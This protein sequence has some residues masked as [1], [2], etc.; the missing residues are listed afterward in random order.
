[1]SNTA[2]KLRKNMPLT[3]FDYESLEDIFSGEFGTVRIISVKIRIRP[4]DYLWV[5]LPSWNIFNQFLKW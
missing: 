5:K 4:S 3:A 1:M 2:Y